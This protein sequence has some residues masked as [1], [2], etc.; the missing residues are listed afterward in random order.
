MGSFLLRGIPESLFARLKVRAARNGRSPDEE[1]MAI[2]S[3]AILLEQAGASSS[4]RKPHR[5]RTK[6][7]T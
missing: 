2:L 6:R 3:E 5:A 4:I 7:K 1:A